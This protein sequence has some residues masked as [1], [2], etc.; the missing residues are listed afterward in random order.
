MR[1]FMKNDLI[2]LAFKSN[3]FNRI[4]NITFYA[5]AGS[6]EERKSLIM[7]IKST[8]KGKKDKIIYSQR[9]KA[10]GNYILLRDGNIQE[11]DPQNNAESSVIFFEEYN[12]N[13]GD[14]YDF[15]IKKKEEFFDA[16]FLNVIEL[17]K[18]KNKDWK[19]KALITRQLLNPFMCIFLSALA[20]GL[21]FSGE[22]SRTGNEF[23]AIKAY[24]FCVV[25]LAIFLYLF[26][27]LEKGIINYFLLFAHAGALLATDLIL[28]RE[29]N[30]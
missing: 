25:G 14:Y 23:Q 21:I 2:N 22:F 19:I 5:G 20:F 7:Y 8:E 1:E 4:G 15:N 12:L 28:I 30:V 16:D 9:A 13:L 26:F 24:F 11:F 18:V 17:L 6:S 27:N 3:D 10:D 29:R